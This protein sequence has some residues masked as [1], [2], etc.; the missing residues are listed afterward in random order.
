MKLAESLSPLTKKIDESTKKI[1]EVIKESISE[2]DIEALPNSS[3]ISKSMREIIGSLI[4]SR[5]SLKIT[6]DELGRANILGVPIQVSEGDTIEINDIIYELT[7]EMYNVLSSTN[8][9]GRTMKNEDDILM[10][11]NIINDLSYTGRVDRSSNTR[12]FFTKTPPK[13]VEK[14]QSRVFDEIIDDSDDL[15]GEGVK[16]I[17]PS[18]IIDIYTRLQVVLALKLSGYT[19]TLTEASNLIDELYKRGAIQN[20]QQYRNALNKFLPGKMELP[21]K[22]LEQKAFNTRSR[23]GEHMLIVMDKS[24]HGEHLSQHLQ[25]HNRQFKIA[26]TFL[27]GYN[28]IFNITNSNNNVYFKN[29]ITNEEDF[30]QKT[31]PQG[32]Y[33]IESLNKAIRRIIIDKGHYTENEYPFTVKATSSTLVSIAEI[34]PQGAIIGFVFQDS[35]RSLLGLHETIL[36]KKYIIYQKILL[37]LY[38]LIIFSLKQILLKD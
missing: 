12:T 26:V 15:Q 30:I 2:D 8:Y 23:I 36:Y 37:I 22:L 9:T 20:E 21:S 3:A 4:N 6:Q 35:I 29:T 24:T 33:E 32:A 5:N 19:D 11:Y 7:Q 31:I 10:M 17:I 14:I 1:N 27:T 16:I 25:T 28:G 13:L 38:H 18:N 34:K